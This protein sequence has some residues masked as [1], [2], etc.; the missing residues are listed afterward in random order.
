MT[1]GRGRRAEE[2][3]RKRADERKK[4]KLLVIGYLLFVPLRE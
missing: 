2:L 3:M 1:E 4:K